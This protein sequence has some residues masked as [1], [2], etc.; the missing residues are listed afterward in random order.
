[1]KITKKMLSVF[2]ALVMMLS[3]AV[4]AIPVSAEGAAISIGE[5]ECYENGDIVVPISVENNPGVWGINLQVSYPEQLTY[6]SIEKVDTNVGSCLATTANNVITFL[7]EA[8]SEE[9]NI[10]GDG[11]LAN[12]IFS[13]TAWEDGKIFNIAFTNIDRKSITDANGKDLLSSK[14]GA[15]PIALKDGAIKCGVVPVETPAKPG[16]TEPTECVHSLKTIGYKKATYFA[17]GYTGDKQCSK[18]KV[19]VSKGKAISKLKLAKPKFS[20]KAGKKQFK[21]TYK[22]VAGATKFQVRYRIKGKWI[23]KSYKAKKNMTKTIKKLKKGT[24]KVQ[25]RAMIQSGSK[26]AYSNWASVKRAK[27]K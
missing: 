1:M 25:V 18:C 14:D 26:K 27:V 7:I 8:N 16:V 13:T 6:K 12:I 11:V 19:V 10:T 15:V 21:V 22:K 20:V 24:Y 17:A 5:V 4:V 9:K 23:V 2:V 3:I